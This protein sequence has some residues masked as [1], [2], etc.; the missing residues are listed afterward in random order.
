[1]HTQGAEICTQTWYNNQSFIR[2]IEIWT[3]LQWVKTHYLPQVINIGLCIHLPCKRVRLCLKASDTGTERTRAIVQPDLLHNR[4][5]AAR[6][7]KFCALFCSA[8][9]PDIFDCVD[10]FVKATSNMGYHS[11]FSTT[12]WREDCELHNYHL[13]G[14]R[15]SQKEILCND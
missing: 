6:E 5:R 13:G 15:A 12:L 11:V 1:M 10:G 7:W 4:F 8:S 9:L 14:S 2:C 3:K